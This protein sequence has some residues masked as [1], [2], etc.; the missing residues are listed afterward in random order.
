MPTF[1]NAYRNGSFIKIGSVVYE[2]IGTYN[3]PSAV[4]RK[5]WITGKVTDRCGQLLVSTY[6]YN[7]SAY[8]KFSVIISLLLIDLIACI[9][10][11]FLR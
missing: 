6:M 7:G 3:Y 10:V 4:E 11:G 8:H 9:L 2:I 1:Y 5:S